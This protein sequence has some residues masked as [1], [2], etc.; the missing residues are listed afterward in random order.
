MSVIVRI[1]C[2]GMAE[3]IRGGRNDKIN[4][5]VRYA[6]EDLLRIAADEP[7]DEGIDIRG[8]RSSMTHVGVTGPLPNFCLAVLVLDFFWPHEE[9]S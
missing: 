5:L 9:L 1:L 2:I 4:T 6:G 8:F 3:I 7:V